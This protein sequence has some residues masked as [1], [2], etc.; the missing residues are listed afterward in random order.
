MRDWWPW[1]GASG[2][3]PSGKVSVEHVVNVLSRLNAS[4]A[5]EDA[6]TVQPETVALLAN[7]LVEDHWSAGMWKNSYG[8]KG[9]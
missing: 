8:T 4:L 9:R 6:Q 2:A 5:Q 1:N 3:P 7:T